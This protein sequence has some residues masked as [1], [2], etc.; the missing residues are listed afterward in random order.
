MMPSDVESG[1]EDSWSN[2]RATVARWMPEKLGG[3]IIG[4]NSRFF[5]EELDDEDL[6]QLG[7]VEFRALKLLSHVIPAVSDAQRIGPVSLLRLQYMFVFEVVPFA[8]IAIYLS[9][10]SR[11]NGAFEASEGVQQ[12]QV[13]ST[14]FSF[15]LVAS[16]YAGCGMR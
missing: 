7:G 14:W 13:D 1:S 11:W 2:M 10:T 9:Q 4:R 5:S 16:A 15:F 3:L 8:I 6:E 12:H